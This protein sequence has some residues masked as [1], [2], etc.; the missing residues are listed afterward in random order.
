MIK[1]YVKKTSTYPV[2]AT[3][4]K[5]KLKKFFSDNGIVSDS[6]VSVALVSKPKMKDLSRRYL[7]EKD[8]LHNVL[9]FPAGESKGEFIFPEKAQIDLGE[10]VVCYPVAVEEAKTEDKLIE[11]KIIELIEHGAMHLLGKHHE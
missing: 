3:L 5:R 9:S 10:I 11:D 4:I 1:V 7:G 2:S 6:M 8:A